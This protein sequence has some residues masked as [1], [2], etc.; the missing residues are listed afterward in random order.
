VALAVFFV[1]ISILLNV[2]LAVL[3]WTPQGK[4]VFNHTARPIIGRAQSDSWG[5]MHIALEEFRAHLEAPL[6]GDVAQLAA[7]TRANPL[8]SHLL[9]GAAMVLVGLYRLRGLEQTADEEGS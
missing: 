4:T 6:Y 9:L 3:P 7:G 2:V 1:V 8:Q 5:Q